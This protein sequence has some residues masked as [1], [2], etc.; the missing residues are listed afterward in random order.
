MS[1]RWRRRRGSSSSARS[2]GGA[3]GPTA[4]SVLP[5]SRAR[6]ARSSRSCP[7]TIS[8]TRSSRRSR[9]CR[10]PRCIAC[11]AIS[12]RAEA[13]TPSSSCAT[14]RASSA[15]RVFGASRNRCC[16]P[17]FIGR[18][19]ASHRSRMLHATGA[20]MRRSQRWCSIARWCRART[21]RRS[22]RSSRRWHRAG[23]IRCRSS[24]QAS[25]TRKAPPSSPR[26]SAAPSPR[27]SS[28]PPALPSLRPAG[29]R[30]APSPARTPRC[31]R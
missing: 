23:S 24:R 7:A 2:A 10:P 26:F 27:S 15:A 20:P 19:R 17:G 8:R 25:E 28:M 16:A 6:A 11:G 14:P 18:A 5:R 9:H 13:P 30:T 12:P 21:W 29:T 3:I 31:C 22:M 4:S 1:T